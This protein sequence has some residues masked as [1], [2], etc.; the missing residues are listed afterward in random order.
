MSRFASRDL[1]VA[2]LPQEA[3]DEWALGMDSCGG[4]TNDTK[5]GCACPTTEHK[6]KPKPGR[7][8]VHELGALQEQLR[9][10]RI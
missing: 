2:T 3:D 7:P 10:L 8:G 6:P 1:M 5:G 4:C 9:A